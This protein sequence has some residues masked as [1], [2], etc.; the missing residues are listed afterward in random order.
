[1]TSPELSIVVLSWNTRELTKRC[2][3]SL[4]S[5]GTALTREVIVVD[6]GSR[7]GSADMVERDFPEVILIRNTENR[8]YAAGNNQGA[9]RAT[10]EWLCLL[11]SDTEVKPGALDRC[12]EFLRE[13]SDYGIVA[14]QLLNFDGTPQ[15]AVMRF[16]TLLTPLLDSTRLGTFF[17][18]KQLA[19]RQRM[20]DFD[21][22]HSLDVDQPPA[23]VWVLSRKEYGELNG[24]DET[25]SLFFNDVDFCMRLRQRGRR[26]RFLA[27][28]GVFH[29]QGAS[30]RSLADRNRNSLWYRNRQTFYTKHWGRIGR[31]WL[32]FVLRLWALQVSA[33]TRLG[34]RTK[35]QKRVALAELREHVVACLGE[36]D[37]SVGPNEARTAAIPEQRPVGGVE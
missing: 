15:R 19:D 29:H 27:E 4:R 8:L 28:A 20:S 36:G 32:R 9:W 12:V 23:A 34:P 30:T 26:I 6:N 35:E 24:L 13:H 25:L 5:D 1:M 7:D 22:A 37:D 10:G 16:P 3:H 31:G 33:G 11:N 18:G 2:L 21:H 14:P 17:P